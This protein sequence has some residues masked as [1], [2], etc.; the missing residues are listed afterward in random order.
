MASGKGN[1]PFLEFT[2]QMKLLSGYLA[3]GAVLVFGDV[4]FVVT[5]AF[6]FVVVDYAVAVVFFLFSRVEGGFIVGVQ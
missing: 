5:V 6:G 2:R 4:R 1:D 3:K